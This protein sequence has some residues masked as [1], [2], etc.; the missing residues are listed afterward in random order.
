MYNEKINDNSSH[1]FF[2]MRGIVILRYPN[3]SLPDNLL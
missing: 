2:Y 1:I 3:Y